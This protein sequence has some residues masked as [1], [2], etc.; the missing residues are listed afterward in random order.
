MD[1]CDKLKKDIKQLKKDLA[2][3]T[4]V[5]KEK[6]WNEVNE[7]KSDVVRYDIFYKATP[8]TS[9]IEDVLD[10]IKKY[11]YKIVENRIMSRAYV[12]GKGFNHKITI[13]V[14]KMIN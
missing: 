11:D 12:S 8:L 3:K 9:D 5:K 1:D 4:L 14:K 10:V 2:I 6:I 7:S 13:E